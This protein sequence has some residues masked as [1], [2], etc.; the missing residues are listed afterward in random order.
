MTN[1]HKSTIIVW[2]IESLSGF[3]MLSIKYYKYY[4]FRQIVQVYIQYHIEMLQNLFIIIR[5][6]KIK[7]NVLSKNELIIT[8]C[9]SVYLRTH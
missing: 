7:S 1:I 2:R 4:Y 6:H 3:R 5:P 8:V 9:D